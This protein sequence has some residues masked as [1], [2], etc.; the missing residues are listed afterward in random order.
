MRRPTAQLSETRTTTLEAERT[1]ISHKP[2]DPQDPPQRPK[3]SHERES[4]T[5]N[6]LHTATLNMGFLPKLKRRGTGKEHWDPAR[7]ASVQWD[8]AKSIPLK[9]LL[10]M[11]SPLH[12][13]FFDKLDRE[14]EKVDSFYLEREKEMRTK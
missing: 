4:R 3:P 2:D 12:K 10:P 8:L 14:L 13:A 9:D 1:S 11:L 6:I 5:G 7:R